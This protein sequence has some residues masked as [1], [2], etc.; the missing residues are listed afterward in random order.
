[1]NQLV[2]TISEWSND[3]RMS[4]LFARFPEK[5]VNEKVYES[6]L[7]FWTGLLGHDVFSIDSSALASKFARKGLSPLGM[8]TVV[9]EM[10]TQGTLVPLQKYLDASSTSSSWISELVY[11]PFRFGL[12]FVWGQSRAEFTPGPHFDVVVDIVQENASK[13]VN[14][15]TDHAAYSITDF[16]FDASVFAT[17]FPEP[18]STDAERADKI[19]DKLG[20]KSKSRL[21]LLDQRILARH[22]VNSKKAVVEHCEDGSIKIIKFL[23]SPS[24]KA[25]LTEADRGILKIVTTSRTVAAQVTDLESKISQLKAR[26]SEALKS[27]HRS[28]ALL[29]LKQKASVSSLLEKRISSQYTLDTIL[30]K[31]Q[32]AESDSEILQAYQVGTDTLQQVMAATGLTVDRVDAVLDTLQ[33]V[34]ADHEEVEDA[35]SRVLGIGSGVMDDAEVEAELDAIVQEQQHGGMEL[36]AGV[37]ALV[38]ELAGLSVVKSGMKEDGGHMSVASEAE[39][40]KLSRHEAVI[41]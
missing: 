26:A 37:N 33:D 40:A 31:I 18:A 8:D 20:R 27:N 22:L 11:A 38:D 29:Y 13:L 3:H 32:Q 36:D 25:E 21:T 35:L 39:M 14:Y 41:I 7:R 9:A 17:V 24:I 12:S 4:A 6:R 19:D 1:M 15:V 10:R 23:V 30:S 5:E 34:L 28:R 2:A 16:V